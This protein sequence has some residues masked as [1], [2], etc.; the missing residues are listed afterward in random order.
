MTYFTKS[1]SA[2]DQ[3]KVI[4]SI[5]DMNDSVITSHADPVNTTDV[6][7]KR[8]VDNLVYTVIPT[9]MIT[10]TGTS[11]TEIIPELEGDYIIS[12]RNAFPGGPSGKFM[13]SKNEQS[14]NPSITRVNSCAGLTTLE[15]LNIQW[16]PNDTIRMRKDGT[17]YNGNYQV[18]YISNF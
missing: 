15:R 16:N 7:N 13:V 1:N 3:G 9:V 18:K 11:Y 12:V 17:N 4:R 8:Y 6:S 14:R 5:I 2:I 10:L